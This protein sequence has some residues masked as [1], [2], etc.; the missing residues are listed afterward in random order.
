MTGSGVFAVERGRSRLARAVAAALRLPRAGRA[1]PVTLRVT[2]RGDTET[3]DRVLG[4]RRLVTRQ[5]V[6]GGRLVERAG[7]LR[8]VFD[9]AYDGDALALTLVRAT[10]AGLPV[11]VRVVAV[12]R[13]DAT[14][15]DVAVTVTTS[16]AGLLLRY[17]GRLALGATP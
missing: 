14:T 3:W 4:G 10:V 9:G 1:V 11:P 13:G 5:R 17:G 2:R 6:E 12:V 8:L 15:V 7:P 16:R